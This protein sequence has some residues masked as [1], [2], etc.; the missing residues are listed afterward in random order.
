MISLSGLDMPWLDPAKRTRGR[1]TVR[2]EPLLT[3]FAKSD[4]PCPRV[5]SGAVEIQS[6]ADGRT[7][8]CRKAYRNS[9]KQ[10]GM[11]EL[12]NEV[13]PEKKAEAS[14]TEDD[15]ALAY[16][17]CEQGAGV[18]ADNIP[19]TQGEAMPEGWQGS[20]KESISDGG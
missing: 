16:E 14:V 8:T 3:S 7:Y 20:I 12:G 9:L 10:Q 1:E 17:Q 15:I 4:F 5:V 6:Q 18:T 11:M 13:L 19:D 2:A